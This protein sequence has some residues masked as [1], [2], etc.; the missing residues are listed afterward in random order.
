MTL[1]L[2]ILIKPYTVC[3]IENKKADLPVSGIRKARQF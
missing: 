3:T 2:N 1:K